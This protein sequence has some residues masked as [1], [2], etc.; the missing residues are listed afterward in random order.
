MVFCYGYYTTDQPSAR[1]KLLG[2]CSVEINFTKPKKQK[3]FDPNYDEVVEAV[4]K[5][6]EAMAL[7]MLRAFGIQREEILYPEF[8][9]ILGSEKPQE[10]Q[11]K[12]D[13]MLPYLKPF[14]KRVFERCKESPTI[15]DTALAIELGVN[16]VTVCTIRNKLLSYGYDGL[17]VWKTKKM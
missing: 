15:S 14:E 12:E 17:R 8:Q 16:R 11:P 5:L 2:W 13:V 1:Q 4:R 10:V 7:P 9:P 6:G 3:A